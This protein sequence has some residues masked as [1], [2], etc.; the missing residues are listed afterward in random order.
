MEGNEMEIEVSGSC[1]MPCFTSLWTLLGT[2]KPG[3][4]VGSWEIIEIMR[5]GW[6]W[7]YT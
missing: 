1:C 2:V 7:L 5:G 3:V 6:Q 4:R